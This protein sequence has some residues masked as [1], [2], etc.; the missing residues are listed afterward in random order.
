[1]FKR[2]NHCD[3]YVGLWVIY[4]L[5]GVI[6]S[7]GIINQFLQLVM[8]LWGL[9]AF[10]KYINQSSMRRS[11]ILKA[12]FILIIMY[13]LYGCIHIMFGKRMISSNYVYLQSS[14]NSLIPIFLFYYFTYKGYLTSNR[15]RIYLPIFI[16]TCILLYYKKE[17]SILLESN[18]EEITNNIGYMFTSLIPLLFFYSKKPIFQ[19]VLLGIILLF[20]FMGMKRGA[21]LLGVV[22]SVLLLYVILKESSRCLKLLTI[23]LSVSIIIGF[24]YY[25]DYLMT[26]SAYFVL[27]VEQT[28]EGNSSGRDILYGKL[29]DTLF[30]ESNIFVILFGRGADSTIKIV[31][32]YAHQDWLETFCNNGLLGVFILFLFFYSFGKSVLKSKRHF[33]TMM[34]YSF[35]ILFVITFSKSLISMSIQNLDLYQSLLIGYFAYKTVESSQNLGKEI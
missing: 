15:I 22:S 10:F 27:R 24:F 19:Y 23:L 1:M 9:T 21:I 8:L 34:Y 5:Q 31:G 25:I 20:I 33:P 6:Y 3:I 29:W 35:L 11:S 4:M 17:A 7:P 30:Q 16:L 18:N 32:N 12:T 26:N 14:L 13:A 28:L 2:I